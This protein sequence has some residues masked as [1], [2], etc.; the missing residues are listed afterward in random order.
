MINSGFSCVVFIGRRLGAPS[1]FIDP[2]GETNRCF[3]TSTYKHNTPGNKTPELIKD[4]FNS[5][6]FTMTNGGMI[7][8]PTGGTTEDFSSTK[9][10]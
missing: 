7:K 9:Y 1:G 8:D 3:E 4:C 6:D 2:E 10:E 5:L